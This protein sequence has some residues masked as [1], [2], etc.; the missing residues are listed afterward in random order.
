VKEAAMRKTLKMMGFAAG[1]VAGTALM[2]AAQ[3]ATVYPGLGGGAVDTGVGPGGTTDSANGA[4][5]ENRGTK[6]RQATTEPINRLGAYGTSLVPGGNGVLGTGDVAV[7][8]WAGTNPGVNRNLSGYTYGSPS[9]FGSP[10]V[11]RGAGPP[12]GVSR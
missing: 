11:A 4:E 3:N 6:A 9:A 1:L 12:P 7:G 10:S 5:P 8:N 2:A